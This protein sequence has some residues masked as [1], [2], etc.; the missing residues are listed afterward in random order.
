MK[1]FTKKC[2]EYCMLYCAEK[3]E[4]NQISFEK[5]IKFTFAF[6][7]KNFRLNSGPEIFFITFNYKLRFSCPNFFYRFCPMKY[8]YSRINP[9]RKC[10]IV[11]FDKSVKQ[12]KF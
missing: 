3:T 1:Y 12:I 7:K 4:N 2:S 11:L 9:S 8:S 6:N 10:K 5:N